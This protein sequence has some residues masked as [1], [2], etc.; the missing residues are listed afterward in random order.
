MFTARASSAPNHMF[1]QKLFYA[2]SV[3]T[4]YWF[5]QRHLLVRKREHD[6][7]NSKSTQLGYLNRRNLVTLFM[8]SGGLPFVG[9]IHA[10]I[11]VTN[12]YGRTILEAGAW[13]SSLQ[14]HLHGVKALIAGNLYPG[15]E[16]IATGILIPFSPNS[17]IRMIGEM[18]TI[19]NQKCQC[20]IFQRH[21]ML[22]G[23]HWVT[24]LS[25]F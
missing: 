5:C 20:M 2:N 16:T 7:R 15:C 18:Y 8:T 4:L 6:R 1:M 14:Q 11:A 12:K 10:A 22:C 24:I 17:E 9:A 19:H 25:R 13:T 23:L 3:Y 21:I